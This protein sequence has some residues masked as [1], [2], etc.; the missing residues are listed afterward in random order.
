MKKDCSIKFNQGDIALIGNKFCPIGSLIQFGLKCKYN[1]VAWLCSDSAVLE[2]KAKG[3]VYTPLQKYLNKTWYRIKIIRLPLSVTDIWLTEECLKI[4]TKPQSYLK[5]L[6]IIFYYIF[7]SKKL[8]RPT[9]SSS[10]ATALA[11]IG[12]F[13]SPNMDSNLVTPKDFD[14]IKNYEVIYE[15]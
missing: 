3:L 9:C 2:L 4:F 7:K 10:L 15:N 5:F 12:Y 6:L 13:V 11:F 14:I 8:P 1:H